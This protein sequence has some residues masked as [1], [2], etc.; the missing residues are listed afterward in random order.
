M[1][2]DPVGAQW[3][4]RR[5]LARTDQRLG[6]YDAP[7]RAHVDGRVSPGDALQAVFR[8]STGSSR[9]RRQN[10]LGRGKPLTRRRLGRGGSPGA[11]RPPGPG[12]PGPP[13]SETS[14]RGRLLGKGR[15]LEPKLRGGIQT[16]TQGM[17]L[18]STRHRPPAIPIAHL[19]LRRGETLGRRSA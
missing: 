12:S 9:V 17:T 2:R 13:R 18:V 1:N 19:Q 16:K 8:T 3:E 7:V 15:L 10:G 4:L 5:A 14:A 11:V 6:H